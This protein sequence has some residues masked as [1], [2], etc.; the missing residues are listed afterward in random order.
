VLVGRFFKTWSYANR[1]QELTFTPFIVGRRIR[2][3]TPP[4]SNETHLTWMVVGV[5]VVG[6]AIMAFALT[7]DR[8][9][10]ARFQQEF[11]KQRTKNARDAGFADR[12]R[13]AMREAKA[14]R[15]AAEAAAKTGGGGTASTAPP[16]P[17]APDAPAAPAQP[18]AT[19]EPTPPAADAPPTDP[20]TQV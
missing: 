19:T 10:D 15:E 2:L 11:L 18:D 14:A 12:A 9:A 5:F 16:A 8:A 6:V 1:N 4:E 20:T 3:V 7:R 17:A 13:T